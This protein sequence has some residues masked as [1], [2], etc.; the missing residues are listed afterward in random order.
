MGYVISSSFALTIIP[1]VRINDRKPLSPIIR[2]DW[3][4]WFVPYNAKFMP[5]FEQFLQSLLKGSPEV[6]ALLAHNPFADK[7]PNYLRVDLYQF[8]L[9]SFE[10][11]QQSGHWWKMKY[12]GPFP[13]LPF[14]EINEN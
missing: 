3:L 1:T 2:L 7:P 11:R 14:L 4:L 8:Q 12:L 13:P 9:T 6:M 5:F 10:E